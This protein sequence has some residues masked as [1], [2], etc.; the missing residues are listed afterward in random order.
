MVKRLSWL[1]SGAALSLAM[2][3]GAP[4]Y[5]QARGPANDQTASAAGVTVEPALDGVFRVFESHPIVALA[6]A[7]GLAEQ[8]EF[9]TAVVRDPRFARDVRNV[10]VE[11]GASSQQPV[12]DRYLAGETVP[13]TELRKVWNETVAWVPPPAMVGFARFF[14]AV[15]EVNKSLPRERQIRVWLGE[16]PLDWTAPSRD[17]IMGAVMARG[18]F[19]AAL[20]R[21]KVLA[22]GE[23]ALLIYGVGHFIGGLPGPPLKGE[24]DAAHP[25]AMFV[26]LPHAPPFASPTCAPLMPQVTTLW[27]Q[28]A[29]ATR[30]PRAG[31]AGPRACFTM[32]LP[33][34]G[35]GPGGPGPRPGEPAP[36]GPGPG[37]GGPGLGPGGSGPGGPGPFGAPPPPLVGDG[38]LFLGPLEKLAQGPAGPLEL[39]AQGRYLP[40]YLF[41][42]ELR[43][44]IRRR[45]ELGGMPLLPT[46]TGLTI[47]KTDYALDLEAAGFRER[48]DQLFAAHDRNGDG[49]ITDGEYRDP[50]E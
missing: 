37:P 8:M 4:A 45:S 21:D 9:Y 14:A 26:I 10:V 46:P 13:Y 31:D 18:T 24:I 3:L 43:R 6:D 38:V 32:A 48:I 49:V 15:R 28:P 11:F 47:R 33:M 50:L 2:V 1:A 19:P 22:R 29:L 35:P 16:P 39:L 12:I 7:H 23:K 30:G 25:G 17:D 5:G 40:D 44:E 34:M 41:D 42:A 36:G 27:P 20:V